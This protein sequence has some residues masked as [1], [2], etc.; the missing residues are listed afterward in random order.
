MV[1]DLHAKK[2]AHASAQGREEKEG[3][4]RHPPR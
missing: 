2:G 1:E 4:F 3:L